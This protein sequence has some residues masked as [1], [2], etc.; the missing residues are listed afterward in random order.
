MI[1]ATT[2][3]NQLDPERDHQEIAFRLTCHD[4]PWDTVRALDFAFFRTFAAPKISV[5][6]DSTGEFGYRPQKRYDDTDLILSEILEG[7][8]DSPRGRA[9]L[10][11]MNRIHA[12]F[13]I[14]NEEKLYVLSAVLYE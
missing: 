10:R 8:Y 7:G 6:L 14:E 12:R 2:P 4:F 3:T 13:P 1:A 11:R 5:L 9:A